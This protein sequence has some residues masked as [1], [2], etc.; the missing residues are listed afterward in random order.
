MRKIT[1]K[2][3]GRI[4][5]ALVIAAMFAVTAFAVI[6]F[7]VTDECDDD[8]VLGASATL[9]ITNATTQ[10]DIQA[11]IDLLDA[12]DTLTVTGSLVLADDYEPAVG[13]PWWFRFNIPADRTVLWNA[14]LIY[15]HNDA[16]LGIFGAGTFI[17]AAGTIDVSAFYTHNTATGILNGDQTWYGSSWSIDAQDESTLIVNG[18]LTVT[19]D[20]VTI[21][22]NG[23]GAI[24][25]INGNLTI[26]GTDTELKASR[27]GIATVNGTLTVPDEDKYVYISGFLAKSEFTDPSSVEGY[28]EYTDGI[29]SVFVKVPSGDDGGDDGGDGTG[30][31][32]G[33]DDTGAG[34]GTGGGKD[35]TLLYVAIAVIVIVAILV[36][37]YFFVLKKK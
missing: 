17:A 4:A 27:G 22:A 8:A 12:G 32:N 31:G 15:R 13:D 24:F 34:A 36:A 23:P 3:R 35:N 10:G 19:G 21:G 28:F 5:L 29:S 26:T 6:S 30:D 20:Y 37:L 9:S 18:N 2:S 1:D 33:D 16:G 11:A 7:S 25:T 14:T